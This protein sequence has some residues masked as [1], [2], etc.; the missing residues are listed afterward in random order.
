MRNI[1]QLC[2]AANMGARDG[3]V[4]RAFASHQCGPGSN[5]GVD[6]ICGLSLLLVLSFASRGFSPSTQVFPSPQ[7][8]TFPNYNST[9]NQVD[10][11][12]LCGC[13]TSKSLFIYLFIF[14]ALA[15]TK[16]RFSPSSDRSYLVRKKDDC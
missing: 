16:P 14:S 2:L 1:V 5:P 10:E 9:R 8:P 15:K 11:E 3:A 13:A 6:A 12:P 4:V 7:K